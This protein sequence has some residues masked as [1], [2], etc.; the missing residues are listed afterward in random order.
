[1]AEELQLATKEFQKMQSL[2]TK[3]AKYTYCMM[4]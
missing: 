4:R 1:M 3:V 2:H